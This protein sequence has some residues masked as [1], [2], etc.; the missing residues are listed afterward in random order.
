MRKPK[1]FAAV[2]LF[3]SFG[4]FG[5]AALAGQETGHDHGPSPA[6]PRRPAA[7]ASG[8]NWK[9]SVFASER[10][11]TARPN[12][13]PAVSGSA[14]ANL[15]VDL[16]FQY[17]GP[18]GKV[19]P[20]A[21]VARVG[22]RELETMGNVLIHSTPGVSDDYSIVAWL[23]S[24]QNPSPVLRPVRT[25]QK[26]GTYSLYAADVPLGTTTVMLK[27]GDAP[28]IKL[29]FSAKKKAR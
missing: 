2:A 13:D 29:D 26:F 20:P 4:M 3:A 27:F 21:L 6:A 5:A 24:A 8:A 16:D 19:H 22:D 7:T 17:L 9:V 15:R 25:G 12:I 10:Y 28:A 11:A 14:K 18:T 1:P 23:L